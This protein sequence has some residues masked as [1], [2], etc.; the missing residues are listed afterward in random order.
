VASS[1]LIYLEKGKNSADKELMKV[2]E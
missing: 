1:I 2:E